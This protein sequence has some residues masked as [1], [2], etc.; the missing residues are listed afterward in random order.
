MF[1]SYTIL[2]FIMLPTPAK[3]LG[4]ENWSSPPSSIQLRLFYFGFLSVWITKGGSWRSLTCR[5][6]WGKGS[7]AWLASHSAKRVFFSEWH[8]KL[9]DRQT[10]CVEIQ[11]N[12]AEEWCTCN[13][14][15][16][17]QLWEKKRGNFLKHLVQCLNWILFT[18]SL[19][20]WINMSTSLL[21]IRKIFGVSSI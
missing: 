17:I 18:L 10:K 4:A 13:L 5:W 9:L 15:C 8:Q 19:M 3:A 11:G 6:W 20:F 16:K 1:L 7:S 14:P 21:I 2:D 12:Y